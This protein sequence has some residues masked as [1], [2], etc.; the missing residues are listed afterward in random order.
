MK[1]ENLKDAGDLQVYEFGY[2]ILPTVAEE[3]LP[4]EVSKVHSLISENGGSIISEGAPVVRQ[5]AYEISKKIE[6]KNLNFNKA[7]FGWIKFEMDRKDIV[8]FK[9]KI[10]NLPNILRFLV[11]KTVKENTMHTPK[12]PMFVKDSHREEKDV[13]KT[14]EKAPVSEAEIDKSIDELVID[15]TL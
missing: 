15:Q 2:H 14:E 8:N 9:N 13:T 11:V 6:N 5:L 10:E 12:I 3:N 1:E 7:Y 4:N